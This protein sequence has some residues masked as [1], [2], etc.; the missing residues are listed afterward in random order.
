M[1]NPTAPLKVNAELVEASATGY[2]T[3]RS[4]YNRYMRGSGIQE[5][6]EEEK[7]AAAGRTSGQRE[8]GSARGRGRECCLGRTGRARGTLS[9]RQ[10]RSSCV[11]WWLKVMPST[12]TI[13]DG[14][15][16]RIL[17]DLARRG[18]AAVREGRSAGWGH[19]V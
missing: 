11:L 7:K 18:S 14:G 1:S 16:S 3:L 10:L 12:S 15:M 17:I 2:Q 9:W 4:V 19:T 5:K 6:E 13:V 8:S